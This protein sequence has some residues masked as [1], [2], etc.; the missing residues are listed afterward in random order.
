VHERL[1]R[2]AS[3]VR[4]DYRWVVNARERA[5]DRFYSLVFRLLTQARARA[6]G[7]AVAEGIYGT[8]RVKVEILACRGE[9]RSAVEQTFL[10]G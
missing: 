3:F 5:F 2:G 7:V 4:L 1:H 9:A 6:R 10:R 8:D